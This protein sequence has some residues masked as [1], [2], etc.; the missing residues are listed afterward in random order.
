VKRPAGASPILEVTQGS[1]AAPG[2]RIIAPQAS[3][4]APTGLAF[5]IGEWFANNDVGREL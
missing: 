2:V 5:S 3:G 4:L 1:G